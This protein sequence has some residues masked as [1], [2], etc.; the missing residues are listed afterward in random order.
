MVW[1]PLFVLVVFSWALERG[2]DEIHP[3]QK[4]VE[5]GE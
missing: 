2:E 3:F 4:K 5:E 1:F